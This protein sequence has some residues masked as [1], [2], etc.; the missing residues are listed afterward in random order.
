MQKIVSASDI[1]SGASVFQKLI[2]SFWTNDLCE[3][4]RLNLQVVF[5]PAGFP[6]DLMERRSN[7]KGGAVSQQG[8]ERR[9]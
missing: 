4:H 2:H 8:G 5:S 7:A 1:L 6:E 3:S 9:C